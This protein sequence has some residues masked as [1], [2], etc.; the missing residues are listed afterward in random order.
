MPLALDNGLPVVVFR[1][2]AS[3]DDEVPFACHI[4]ICATMNTGNLELHMWIITTFPSTV[5]SYE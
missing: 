2:S 3:D 5:H 1:F 4:Y